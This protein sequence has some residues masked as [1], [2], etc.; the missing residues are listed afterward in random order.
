MRTAFIYFFALVVALL[1]NSCQDHRW[2]VDTTAYDWDVTLERF[3]LR[4]LELSKG[5]INEEDYQLLKKEYPDL[6]PLF[7]SGIMHFN[8]ASEQET[9]AALNQFMQNK[10]ISELFLD[11]QESY[12]AGS[13]QNALDEIDL[14]FKTFHHYFPER[15]IPEIGTMVSAF[16]YSTV[17]TD[18]LLLIG[19]DMYLGEEYPNYKLA[20]IPQ[21][22]YKNYEKDY[23]VSDA[24]KA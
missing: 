4:L 14:A 2:E 9:M 22:K 10:D 11:V 19:L 7:V 21:Y 15:I 8:Q 16:N 1:L 6:L 17:V 24:I 3:D 13:L 20:G 5:G 18:S 12:K 23:I